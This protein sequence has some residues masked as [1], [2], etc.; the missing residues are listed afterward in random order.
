MD[1]TPIEKLKKERLEILREFITSERG[2][3]ELLTYLQTEYLIPLKDSK[4]VQG[5]D[6][7]ENLFS[8]IEEIYLL[9]Q[10]FLF[11]VETALTP[12]EPDAVIGRVL[13]DYAPYFQ[14]YSIYVSNQDVAN[15]VLEK[16]N[17]NS[18]VRKFLNDPARMAR[19]NGLDIDSLLITPCQRI[20]RYELLLKTL[21]KHTPPDHQDH[22]ILPA[23]LEEFSNLGKAVDNAASQGT[24][25]AKL[26]G[27]EE[28]ISNIPEVAKAAG[29]TANFRLAMY[30]RRL[31]KQGFL[32][33]IGKKRD[34]LYS[35][36]LFNDMLAYADRGKTPDSVMKLNLHNFIPIDNSFF[37][38]EESREKHKNPL[39]IDIYNCKKSFTVYATDAEQRTSWLN[40]F[41]EAIKE[42]KENRETGF[43]P[44]LEESKVKTEEDGTE[45]IIP[46]I[47]MA[48]GSS[49]RCT[50]CACKFTM[51]RRRH[52]CR[53]C[54]IL[55]CGPC[56]T[57]RICLKRRS[58]E[59]VRACD[60]CVSSI[61][62]SSPLRKSKE[63]ISS[64]DGITVPGDNSV[65]PSSQDFSSANFGSFSPSSFS[66]TSPT[67]LNDDD[68]QESDDE[69]GT[70][71]SFF[72]CIQAYT[73]SEDLGEMT[74]RVGD[75][76]SIQIKDKSG[77][78]FGINQNLNCLGWVD[79]A[80]LDHM[81]V[82]TG[83]E[84]SS[85][86]KQLRL[87]I[88]AVEKD[89]EKKGSRKLSRQIGGLLFKKK[90]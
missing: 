9:N 71:E 61:G 29:F 74:L 37:I 19:A 60:R 46:P 22:E 67:A 58:N 81:P 36:L 6:Q 84:L 80:I 73:G 21:L 39:A 75:V 17:K 63:M 14:V 43:L 31:I 86:G 45:D 65:S 87:S 20:P 7:I 27:L 8:N 5:E 12:L 34:T 13:L 32:Y 35:F 83:E 66:N 2:Y 85:L 49:Q 25:F 40:A 59:K 89:I 44:T 77:Y 10:Q 88:V 24:E 16:L 57:K 48:D 56:S 76:V 3:L 72:Q 53:R 33:K 54:G 55:V 18:N 82:D 52:H 78:W 50:I 30:G 47:M 26:L 62:T 1:L 15:V 79:P 70:K 28:K 11:A 68:K 38:V 69:L 90:K 4:L 42:A 41:Q 64:A 51:I 23:V